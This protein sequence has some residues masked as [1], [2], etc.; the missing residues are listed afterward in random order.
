MLVDVFEVRS[1]VESDAVVPCFQPIFELRTGRL[2]G[3][4]VLARWQHPQ[5]GLVLPENF[6]AL[7]EENGLIGRLGYQILRKAFLSAPMLPEP[8]AF[9][10]NGSPIQLQDP[11]LPSQIREAADAAGFPLKRLVVEI[12]ESA[13]VSNP[14]GEQKIAVELKALGC[15]LA[16]DDFGSGYS[17]L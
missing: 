7:A 12:T 9:A 2:N 14:E 8:L 1:A 15:R 11:D 13:L 3:F 6:I 16:L 10:V 5:L 17:S 4:E